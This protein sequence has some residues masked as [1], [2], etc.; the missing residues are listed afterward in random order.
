MILFNVV[1]IVR[2]K[3]NTFLRISPKTDT[4][5]TLVGNKFI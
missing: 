4:W 3:L 1:S 2:K 5:N